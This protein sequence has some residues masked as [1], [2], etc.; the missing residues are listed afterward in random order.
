MN[1]SGKFYKKRVD[2]N[3]YTMEQRKCIEESIQVLEVLKKEPLM[4]LGKIQSGKTKTFIG[5]IALGFD[6]GY[7]LS[8]VLTKGTNALSQQTLSRMK[9]EFKGENV[10]IFDIMSMPSNLSPFE[11]KQ[12][13]IIIVKKE[14]N[15]L[16][17]FK[18]FIETYPLKSNK[19][20]MIIDD[21]ADFASIGFEKKNEV[22]D[23]RRIAADINEI[24]GN[25]DECRFIQVTATPYS[26]YLQ[27]ET[28]QLGVDIYPIK[29][30]HTVLVP[31]GKGYIGG[32]YYFNHEENP[33]AQYL[34]KEI[35]QK[36]FDILKNS[37]R[38]VFKEEEVLTH[39]KISGIRKAIMNFIVGGTIRLL[40]N[41]GDE[42]DENNRYSLIIHT[43]IAKNSH[44]RQEDII[45]ALVYK[46]KELINNDIDTLDKLI[47]ESLVDLNESIESYGFDRIDAEILKQEVY[48]AINERMNIS[49][50]NSENEVKNM[51]DERG[52]LELRTPLNIF[53]GGQILDRGI[54]IS[55]L[56]GFVY[57]RRPQKMQQ[58]TVLQ[59]ARMFG[60]RKRED[61]A[62]TRL[63][64]T[65]HLYNQMAKINEFDSVLRK[66]F[67][68]Q[69]NKEGVIFIRRDSLGK[70]IPCSPNKIMLS[71]THILKEHR[72][73]L[74]IG[75]TPKCKS[76]I[77]PIVNKIDKII[78][79]ENL[80]HKKTS[81]FTVKKEIAC[82]IIDLIYK[83]ID[84]DDNY[85]VDRE[86][87]LSL[88]N[89]LSKGKV[90]L[91][92]R[93][94]RDTKKYTPG[95][96]RLM[97]SPDNGTQDG[98][99]AKK[100]AIDDPSLILI[101]QNGKSDKEY[102]WSGAPFWWPVLVTPQNVKSTV[103]AAEYMK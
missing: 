33:L 41:G 47:L 20:C 36:E 65:K 76:K 69:K 2:S 97:N 10:R 81:E 101:K 4:M 17:R 53:V 35:D 42:F 103:Y 63:Y 37:D 21:E 99:P 98:I 85:S 67:E 57:G 30:A 31:S 40:Q 86:T 93:E 56:I 25:L 100:M 88:I 18:D 50:V 51:L 45:S 7:D 83:T 71:K 12:K 48:T 79:N 43:E 73:M 75:F 27:P 91:V 96:G 22:F 29:P 90:H 84:L 34:F 44:T 92:V 58:D 3:E 102:G 70:I 26:L 11:L 46:L 95:A 23:I 78:L 6:N 15:N 61:L 82:D 59:H 28:F 5:T 1:L 8:V 77:T 55:N 62:V 16:T 39:K 80:D 32:D 68:E 38:R 13:M 72:R 87:M 54:T 9:Y 49:V 66:D 60:Y 24:R 94:G 74:P 64:T 19:K 14:K 89:Y 52:Q